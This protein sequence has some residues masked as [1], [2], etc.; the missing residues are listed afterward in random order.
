MSKKSK[1]FILTCGLIATLTMSSAT[2]SDISSDDMFELSMDEL[3]DIEVEIATGKLQK[4]S[5]APAVVNVITAADIKAMGVTE[6]R[7]ILEMIPGV[8]QYP[9]PLGRLDPHF[10]IRG[11]HTADNSQVLVLVDGHDITY[12]VTG[13]SPSAFRMSVAN[14]ARVEVMRSP[15]S[16]LYGADAFAG[17][18]NVITKNASELSGTE[19]GW[20]RGSFNT[21]EVWLQNAVRLDNEWDLS[22]S[23]ESNSSDGDEARIVAYND[24]NIGFTGRASL[25]TKYSYTNTQVSLS[26]SE[27][28]FKIWN[29]NLGEAGTGQ[30]AAFIP[31]PTDFDKAELN[32]LDIQN[33]KENILPGLGIDTRLSYEVQEIDSQFLIFPAFGPFPDGVKGT[34]GATQ[35]KGNF[36]I[37][38]DY[39]NFPGHRL[40]VGAG[41]EW[42]EVNPREVKNFSP[43]LTPF[44]S[45]V[46]VSGD[47]ANVFM[48]R[49]TRAVNH[50]LLQDEWDVNEAWAV[51]AGVRYDDYSDFGNTTNP[52]LAVIWRAHQKLTTKILYG[53]AFRAPSFSEL[54]FINNLPTVGNTNVNAEQI[55][56]YE[57][58]IDYRPVR[59]FNLVL[60]VFDYRI[61]DLIDRTFGVAAQNTGKQDG[62]GF[63]LEATWHVNSKLQLRSFYAFQNAKDSV[64]GVDVPNAPQ[65]QIYSSFHWNF[66]PQ[67]SLGTQLKWIADRKRAEGDPRAE[68]SDYTVVDTTLRRRN[69]LLN[70]DFSFSVRNLFDEDIRGPSVYDANNSQGAAIVN[71]YPMPGRSAYAEVNFNY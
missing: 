20:R 68:I 43:S 52:R 23:L 9:D 61:E 36:S 50:I 41:S 24:E 46:D 3:L 51:T 12:A 57:A 34:P 54:Y 48:L 4:L 32:L 11:I 33:R 14:I 62:S 31:S 2:W 56:T 45:M 1:P 30:G 25:E 7:Q 66:Q 60:S 10:S 38:A 67:W 55:E 58:V 40:L 70:M 19:F 39:T 22:F 27:W 28:V 47:P 69:L 49:Q 26:N 64:T 21:Q 17:V 16:A 13:S 59:T 53:R 63:E 8:S 29:W 18:I 35:N 71:D 65:Q 44:G 42:L 37:R 6:F 5:R 15:G